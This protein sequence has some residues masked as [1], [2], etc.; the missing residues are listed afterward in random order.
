MPRSQVF[1]SPVTP[2]TNK[3]HGLRGLYIICTYTNFALIFR[4]MI[5]YYIKFLRLHSY[6][7]LHLIHHFPQHNYFRHHLN[8]NLMNLQQL[9][10]V[11]SVTK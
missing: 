10:M 1:P 11:Y 6:H 4:Y 9:V 8:H 2:V 3:L 5:P 7:L